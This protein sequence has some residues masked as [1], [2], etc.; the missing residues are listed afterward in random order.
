MREGG[1]ETERD[2]LGRWR[3]KGERKRGEK[4]RERERERESREIEV[5]GT[6]KERG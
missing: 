1:E 6:E 3:E 5:E 4:D 2:S